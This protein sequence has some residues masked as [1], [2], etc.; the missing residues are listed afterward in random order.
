MRQTGIFFL[1]LTI[2]LAF[3]SCKCPTDLDTPRIVEPDNSAQMQLV[4]CHKNEIIN[5]Y[6]DEI[7]VF[8]N[9]I[10]GFISNEAA[11]VA[12]NS[13]ISIRNNS[14]NSL[15]NMPVNLEKDS[16]YLAV[17]MSAESFPTMKI[18]KSKKPNNN[19]PKLRFVNATDD[20]FKIKI[21]NLEIELE[22]AF[23]ETTG[24]IDIATGNRNIKLLRNGNIA[25]EEDLIVDKTLTIIINKLTGIIDF[26]ELTD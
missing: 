17:F 6:S 20:I 7:S 9:I 18:L 14:G 21:D 22:L 16:S 23:S 12:D 26:I 1:A 24:F 5:L 3:T 2:F 11:V 25:F 8:S 19:T 4:N 15:L 13:I 10:P